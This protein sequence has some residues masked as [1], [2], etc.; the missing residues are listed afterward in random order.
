MPGWRS[1]LR[2]PE[3]KGLELTLVAAAV[4]RFQPISGWDLRKD[5]QHRGPKPTR[6]LAPA[7]S[8]YFF[9]CQGDATQLWLKSICDSEQDR[10]DGFGIVLI[11]D[12]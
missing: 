7:G 3:T 10:R 2:P 11:G 12:C 9:R 6:F 4:P 1:T 8:A 5:R